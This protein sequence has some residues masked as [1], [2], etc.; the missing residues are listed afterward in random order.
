MSSSS[1]SDLAVTF[2]SI[3]RRL[4]EAQGDSPPDSTAPIAGE[5]NEQIGIAAGLM[6]AALR[7]RRDRGRHRGGTGRRVG[8]NGLDSLRSTALEIGRAAR[9]RRGAEGDDDD[10]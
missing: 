3:P 2:R 9:D 8:R 4:R 10:D 5:L 1:P 6:H 7:T